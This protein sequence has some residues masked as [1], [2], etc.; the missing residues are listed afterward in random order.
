MNLQNHFADSGG[1]AGIR[2]QQ[3]CGSACEERRQT[4]AF[5]RMLLDW[6]YGGQPRDAARNGDLVEKC[7]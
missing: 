6:N 3:Q 1:T 2:T 5:R 7:Y 4:S